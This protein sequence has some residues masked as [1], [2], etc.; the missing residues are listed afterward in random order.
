MNLHR[1]LGGLGI[2]MCSENAGRWDDVEGVWEVFFL[3]GKRVYAGAVFV[4]YGRWEHEC[5][6]RTLS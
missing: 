6:S 4:I 1:A 2:H 5:L 3:K